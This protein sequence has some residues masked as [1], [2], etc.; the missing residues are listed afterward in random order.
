MLHALSLAP[1]ALRLEPLTLCAMPAYPNVADPFRGKTRK[2][3]PDVAATGSDRSRRTL[4][5]R[6]ALSEA[7][8]AA[9]GVLSRERSGFSRSGFATL[10]FTSKQLDQTLGVG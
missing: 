10:G 9:D 5:V 4:T 6:G 3:G 2:S 7:S 1:C 8:T